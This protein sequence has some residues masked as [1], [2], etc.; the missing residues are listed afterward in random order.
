MTILLLPTELVLRVICFLDLSELSALQRSHSSF[1]NLIR[2]S[3]G[4]QY[5]FA[6]AVAGVENNDFNDLEAYKRLS[7]LRDRNTAWFNLDRSIDFHK[8]IS[9]IASPST[10]Y[11]LT[12]GLYFRGHA[13]KRSMHYCKL[14]SSPSDTP[15]WKRID[16]DKR[17]VDIGVAAFEH[18]LIAILTMQSRKLIHKFFRTPNTLA[19][20]KF[21]I[22]ISLLELSTGSSHPLAKSPTLLIGDSE[23]GQPS[24][25][26]EIVGEYLVLVMTYRDRFPVSRDR[27][28]VFEWKTGVVN[29]QRQFSGNS[30]YHDVIFL[31]PRLLLLPNANF[32]TL[33]IW[34]IPTGSMPVPTEPFFS[35]SLPPLRPGI[36]PINVSCR[37]EPN[38]APSGLRHSQAPFHDSA[39]DAVIVFSARG[40]SAYSLYVHRSALVKACT[41]HRPEDEK[42]A[43]QYLPVVGAVGRI[44]RKRV[45]IWKDWG[46]PITRIFDSSLR[47]ITTTAG[48]RAIDA[49]F[50]LLDF[51]PSTVKRA[52]RETAP[53]ENRKIVCEPE[54]VEIEMFSESV[55]TELSYVATSIPLQ[56]AWWGRFR[57]MMMDEE[58]LIVLLVGFYINKPGHSS[59]NTTISTDRR[60]YHADRGVTHRKPS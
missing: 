17:L 13:S 57:G 49:H 52:L 7:L 32:N 4:I 38:P 51:N 3:S 9:G 25:L 21:I 12:G 56:D 34:E 22:E 42:R 15:M 60:R 36:T 8:I 14:P 18:N 5:R 6:A 11:D 47:L 26:I 16:V 43:W 59:G 35:F 45:R 20:G 48:Q 10:I 37:A 44:P 40:L 55:T 33:D 28:M 2:D 19:S 54:T 27:L 39:E 46:P 29:L 50:R 41:T 58:R 53:S 1:R 24:I 31:T 23:P 30:G